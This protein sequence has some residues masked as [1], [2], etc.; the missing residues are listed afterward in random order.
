MI[1]T[2]VK[3]PNGKLISLTYVN[4]GYLLD[5]AGNLYTYNFKNEQINTKEEY[6]II[7]ANSVENE[8]GVYMTDKGGIYY[9]YLKNRPPM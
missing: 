7:R 4:D 2:Y 6:R 3:V 5:K 9:I 8:M 1:P